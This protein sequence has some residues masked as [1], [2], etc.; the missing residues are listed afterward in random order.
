MTDVLVIG[1]GPAGLSAARAA[2]AAGKRTV[3]A[4]AEPQPPYWRPRLPEILR[5]GAQAETI[6]MKSENFLKSNGIDFLSSKTALSIDPE[7]RSV[8]WE[9][10]ETTEYG[11]LVLACGSR[12]NLPAVPG[13]GRVHVLRSYADALRI[14]EECLKTHKAFIVGGG[15]LGLEAAYALAQSGC[16]VAVSDRNEYPLSRQLDREGGLF[17]KQLL[18]KAGIAVRSAADSA[19]LEKD[20]NG[21]CVVAAAGVLPSTEL[22]AACG[23]AVGRGVIVDSAMRTSR[24]SIYAC[25]DVAQFEGAC[26]GLMPVASA[27]GEVAGINAAGGSAIYK[28]VLPSPMLSV[29]GISILSIGS[30]EI[31]E[32]AKALRERS[33]TNYALAV[34]AGGRLTGA[35]FIGNTSAGFKF[36]KYIEAGGEVG[37]VSSFGEVL[38]RVG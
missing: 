5:T 29:A 16:G 26:P 31:P 25:G 33:G 7:R 12:A 13:A 3:L 30:T 37:D 1:A 11:A 38:A 36:K 27:Q 20:I 35:A 2:A 8:R 9:D 23:L 32:G 6:L 18:E 4:G 24:E 34:V 14:R 15:V 17:L 19:E 10:G 21:A 28:K 22:A